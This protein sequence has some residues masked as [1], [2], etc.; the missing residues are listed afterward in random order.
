[1]VEKQKYLEHHVA[2]LKYQASKPGTPDEVA[3]A[4]MVELQASNIYPQT[5]EMLEAVR[6]AIIDFRGGEYQKVPEGQEGMRFDRL[7]Q[8]CRYCFLGESTS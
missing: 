6:Q 8:V 4:F 2:Q 1:M 3:A 7:C 5:P